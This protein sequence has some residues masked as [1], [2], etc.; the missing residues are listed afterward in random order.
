M[1]MAKR[2]KQP[3]TRQTWRDANHLDVGGADKVFLTVAVKPEFKERVV[4][5][6]LEREITMSELIRNAIDEDL[7]S[8]G[9]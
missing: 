9:H 6:A 3:P 1:M 5:A 2:R 8:F 4:K 7:V